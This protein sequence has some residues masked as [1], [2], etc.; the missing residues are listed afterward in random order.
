MHGLDL[1]HSV[2]EHLGVWS[3][4]ARVN[5]HACTV[6]VFSQG[7]FGCKM[8]VMVYMCNADLDQHFKAYFVLSRSNHHN[9]GEV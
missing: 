6:Y 3:N 1:L 9:N 4:G 2:A 5:Y 7:S 8:P